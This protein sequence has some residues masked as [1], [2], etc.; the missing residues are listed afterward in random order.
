MRRIIFAV[1]F[2][3][4]GSAL[5]QATPREVTEFN[6]TMISGSAA[7]SQFTDCR[8]SIMSTPV[9]E[10]YAAAK[11]YAFKNDPDR[12]KILSN[13][14]KLSKGQKRALVDFLILN[15]KCQEAFLERHGSNPLSD[16]RRRYFAME[17][18]VYLD[19]LNGKISIAEGNRKLAELDL[20]E[21]RDSKIE[22]ERMTDKA[23][24]ALQVAR[25]NDLAE[26]QALIQSIDQSLSRIRSIDTS[27]SQSFTNCS[28]NFNN[29]NCSTLR[30]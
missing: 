12:L 19:M 18:F 17:D 1:A 20:N 25:Q 16:I 29:I 15:Q 11:V 28:Q 14:A 8:I 4:S 5:A 22:L 30:Y 6:T 23:R 2:V 9:G 13:N 3:V 27:P 26:R 24:A 7:L 10:R 21:G